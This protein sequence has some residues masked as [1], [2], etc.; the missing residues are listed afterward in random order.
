[1]DNTFINIH[2]SMMKMAMRDAFNQQNLVRKARLQVEMFQ[3]AQEYARQVGIQ[4]MKAKQ[5]ANLLND[6]TRKAQYSRT[7]MFN[8]LFIIL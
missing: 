8:V 3:K 1:M 5:Y 2:D 4:E 7:M 6:N